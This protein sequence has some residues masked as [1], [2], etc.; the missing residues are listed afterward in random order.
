MLLEYHG[1]LFHGSQFQPDHPTVQGE[2]LS[3]IE[4]LGIRPYSMMFAGRTDAG[5]HAKGQVVHFDVEPDALKEVMDLQTALNSKLPPQI[6]VRALCLDAAPAFHSQRHADYKWYRYKIYLSPA[7]SAWMPPDAIW[8]KQPL[9]IGAMDDAARLLEGRH[10]F[11][12]F[13]CRGTDL[14][15]DVCDIMLARFTLE[16]PASPDFENSNAALSFERNDLTFDASPLACNASNITKSTENPDYPGQILN[17][18]I[19]GDRFLY[20]M[21]RN[22]L[23]QLLVIGQPD[24][25]RQARHTSSVF[26]SSSR[27][28]SQPGDILSLLAAR[29]RTQAA[30][31]APANGLSLMSV[32]YPDPIDYFKDDPLRARL[33]ELLTNH[34]NP[35]SQNPVSQDSVQTVSSD[36]S[37]FPHETSNSNHSNQPQMERMQNEN[38][39]GKA[40]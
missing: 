31:A 33:A 22:L 11:K 5:V 1:A 25:Q 4:G 10:S 3:A 23:G 34:A 37:I 2:L 24:R 35:A 20:K 7:R 14:P 21:V 27:L 40:S 19:V 9:N 13:Q 8:I 38:V 29:D 36:A 39:F 26:Q 16:S 6:S 32:V 12:S 17:F 28:L 15:D 18:D 30:F